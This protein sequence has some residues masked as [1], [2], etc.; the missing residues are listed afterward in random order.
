MEFTSKS[1][2]YA[3]FAANVYGATNNGAGGSPLVRSERN[4]LPLP[5][6]D[7]VIIAERVSA[8]GFMARAYREISTGRVIIAYAGTTEESSMDWYA[9]NVPAAA[10]LPSPQVIE[11]ARF[12]MDV[13]NSPYGQSGTISFTGH[14]LGGGLASLMAVYFNH[15]AIVFD[16][17]PFEKSADSY[18]AVM[19]VQVALV[20]QGYQ[21]PESFA[22]YIA[23]DQMGG[24]FY[25]S[26]SR[27]AR[28]HN[29]DQVFVTGEVLSLA[30]RVSTDVIAQIASRINIPLGILALSIDKIQSTV[31]ELDV[32]A[33]SGYGWELLP[34]YKGGNPVDLH[35][36]SLLAGLLI[37]EDFFDATKDRQELLARVFAGQYS[38]IKSS[39]PRRSTLL[40][41]LIQRHVAD[42]QALDVLAADIGKITGQVLSGY[43]ATFAHTQGDKEVTMTLAAALVDAVLAGMYAQGNGRPKDQFVKVFENFLNDGVGSL[44]FDADD[45]G[46]QSSNGLSALREYLNS[47]SNGS[48]RNSQILN[49]ARWTIQNTAVG[50]SSAGPNDSRSDVMI[51]V[52]GNNTF[53]GGGGDDIL[54]GGIG[55]DDFSGESGN[56]TLVGGFGADSYRFYTSDSSQDSTDTIIDSW[57][58]GTIFFDDVA[59]TAGD[60]ISEATW[61]DS[62]KKLKLTYIYESFGSALVISVIDTG[63]IIRVMGWS[64]GELGIVLSG[65]VPDVTGISMTSDADLFGSY[66]ANA[67]NDIVNGLAGNDG[68]E[69][70]AG[71][72]YLNGGI[73]S[74]LILGGAG[75]DRLFGGAGNDFIYDGSEQ[76]D[77]R[78]LSTQPNSNGKS[79]LDLFEEDVLA[80]GSSLITKGL[81]WYVA[82]S[83]TGHVVMAPNW[84]IH[85]PDINPGGSDVID[86]GDGDDIVYA[87][88]GDDV[89]IGGEGH[90]TLVGG[91]DHD[92]ISGGSGND[93]IDGDTGYLDPPQ[94]KLTFRVSTGANID[95]N[96]II[97]AG[98]GDDIVR[99]NGGSDVIYGG[100]GNDEL[101]GRGLGN[102]AANPDDLDSDYIDGGSGND[103]IFGDDGNDM[104]MGNS[105]NDTIRG[106]NGH[107]NVRA[108]DD[109]IDGGLGDD[110]LSGDGGDD[111]IYGGAGADTLRGDASDIAGAFHGHDLLSGG[112]G[113]DQ[114][115]GGGG[116][117]ILYGDDGDDQ[118]FGDEVA[119]ELLAAQFHGDDVIYGGKGDDLL[120]G[121][122]GD[123]T[124]SGGEDNDELQGG[125]GNDALAGG[126]GNDTLFGGDGDDVLRGDVGVDTL[127]G[128]AG[129]DALYGGEG[130][131]VLMGEHGDDGLSGGSGDDVLAGG[132]G[133]DS[134]YGEQGDDQLDGGEGNDALFGGDGNDSLYGGA[135]ND[136]I[137]G[138][139]GNDVINGADGDDEIAG[140]DGNDSL[141][142]MQG[143][144]V[145]NG[146]SGDDALKGGQGNDLLAGGSGTNAYYFDRGF[147]SD[148]VQLAAGSQDTLQFQDGI[149]VQELGFSC[150]GD[151]LLIQMIGQSDQIVITNFF[152]PGVQ[153]SIRT[154]DGNSY[155]RVAFEQG[156]MLTQPTYGSANGDSLNGTNLANR[157]YGLDGNDILQGGEGAD[158]LDG[159][160]GNDTLSDGLGSDVMLGGAGDDIFHF[161][162]GGSSA[163]SDVATGGAGNDTYYVPWYSGFDR[164]TGLGDASSGIDRIVLT[165]ISSLMVNNYQISG[166]DLHLIVGD[167]WSGATQNSLLLEGFLKAGAPT[168]VIEFSNGITMTAADFN[169]ASWSGTSGDDTYAGGFVPDSIDGADGNDTLSG[170][171]GG[172]KIWG[173][174]GNDV[175][176]GNEGNDIL[177][178]GTG[179]DAVYG[180][181]GDD[182]IHSTY[183]WGGT[184]Q[185]RGGVGDDTYYYL[186]P[187]GTLTSSVPGFTSN[188]IEE[189]PGEGNDTVYTNYYHFTLSGTEVENLVAETVN[190]GWSSWDNVPVYRQLVGNH[191]NNT[192]RVHHAGGFLNSHDYYLLDGG[193]G[194][195]TLY[196]SISFDTYV[197]DSLGDV[198]VEPVGSSSIDTVRSS[199]SYS[200]AY[201]SGVENIELTSSDT[202]ATGNSGNNRLD[203]SMATGANTLIGGSGDD[204][205]IIDYFD[206]VVEAENGGYDKIVIKG[207]NSVTKTFTIPTGLNVEIFE[208]HESVS[209]GYALQGDDQN[210]ILVGNN[211]GNT[212]R[213]G[214]GDDELRAKGN[215]SSSTD[216]LYGE[217]GN[218]LLISQSGSNILVGGV[219]NDTIQLGYGTDQIR[220]D[221]GDGVDSIFVIDPFYTAGID[222]L[223]FGPY[224]NS[225][226]VIWSRS[227]NDLVITFSDI[228]NDSITI[229]GYWKQVDGV[230]ELSGVVDQFSFWNESGYRVGSTPEALNN[231]APV[232]NYW[233]L[234]AAAPIGMPF[235]YTLSADSFSDEDIN[236]LVYSVDDLPAWLT[237]NPITK[238]FFGTPSSDDAQG[239]IQVTAT[240]VFGAKASISLTISIMNVIEGTSGDDSLVGTSEPDMLIGLAGNDTLNGG[241]GADHMIGGL[242][243]DSYT[244]DNS[245]DLI[246]E[247]ELEG[248]DLVTS[249]VSY[250]LGENVENLTLSGSA[251]SGHG[252]E[253][254]NSI[255]GNSLANYLSGGAGDDSLVGNNG[256]DELD[257]DSGNDILNGGSGSDYMRGGEGDDLYIVGSAGDTVEEWMLE[258]VDTVQSSVTYTLSDNVEHLTLTGSSAISGSGNDLQ[259]SL[260]GNS[261]VNTL[262]GYAGDDYLDGKAGNDT[263]IGGQGDDTYQVGSTGDV[264]TELAGEGS[265]TVVSIVTY[266]LSSNVEH[267]TLTGTAAINGTGNALSN[268]LLGNSNNNSLSGLAGDDLLEGMGGT[269]TLTGGLGNDTYHMARTYGAD[270]VV[271]N[272]V[273]AGNSDIARFLT[274]VTYDQ[275]WFRRPASSNNLEIS[276]IGTTDKLVIKDWYLGDRYRVEEIRVDDGAKVLHAA[277]VQALVAAMATLTMPAQGQTTLNSTQ[278]QALSSTFSSTWQ[279]QA[280]GMRM[281]LMGN[282]NSPS[283][284]DLIEVTGFRA[285][286]PEIFDFV[287]LRWARE[288]MDEVPIWLNE[289]RGLRPLEAQHNSLAVWPTDSLMVA[290]VDQ[291]SDRQFDKSLYSGSSNPIGADNFTDCQRL[292]Q[293]M[294]IGDGS[295]SIYAERIYSSPV[296]PVEML[297]L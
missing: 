36:I 17:A 31:R 76:A 65:S 227:E 202:I 84:A 222:T 105:G 71:D 197:V 289:I 58:D 242:G 41:L 110:N 42:E 285:T 25:P 73:G 281:S 187:S 103:V 251:Y 279:D 7:W 258:G 14:S 199:I 29:V 290:G 169:V 44:H 140:G 268:T 136:L 192:I 4:T 151:A 234:S 167:P 91:H 278:L 93:V 112:D 97:D 1:A 121:N 89:V 51:G 261:G 70:G 230:D 133:H 38:D 200:L 274:G 48:I 53:L 217:D 85:S 59:V 266:T 96:D 18:A 182:Q 47:V 176:H 119:G 211:Y 80:I 276:I 79:E 107:A 10:G 118:I 254:D 267:L 75:D 102:T 159:G 203:G 263:M 86:A 95:G 142:G 101:S 60:R 114:I 236:S 67:G 52:E 150:N 243:N 229:Q 16:Q 87:G 240:D 284:I 296:K 168:H 106:D 204:T 201:V 249:S 161:T 54:I 277:N 34:E 28:E 143:N 57:G 46:E 213:G 295:S 233:S 164:I 280:Q 116:S 264:V 23:L 189:L 238:T 212:L 271:E 123:D 214:G 273:T 2:L 156:Y 152:A 126:A 64:S 253:L 265:D 282:Q 205:Y 239:Y 178:D 33:Q 74:D 83:S 209:S 247:S 224:I 12:Y 21:L 193:A 181:A 130:N 131:D 241:S 117:D 145:L 100:S 50:I 113:N 146:G 6:S 24:A 270:T 5:S 287:D 137:G 262:R 172:D 185:L 183:S 15:E 72:D 255:T 56:D 139:A 108:G 208:M 191:L 132:A 160:N 94:D 49:H 138:D 294:A 195:D 88:E 196:G 259:N 66:G 218:D 13:L 81:S 62:T 186:A 245:G 125:H 37:S 272:D 180:D 235:T 220:Y 141:S 190:Y 154:A 99:G 225:N 206:E 286:T 216:Y 174:N 98:D 30:G 148:I 144:D 231:R 293:M 177:Y 3:L 45:L 19:A 232:N 26:P 194:N 257:G 170:G 11:A 207:F 171:P 128:G 269:D 90:D 92:S 20:A 122:G 256:N 260:I 9:G 27:L 40:E 250:H 215:T 39:D 68:I 22:E 237:F 61:Y 157:L 221:R 111:A 292:I 248:I 8:T 175:I 173:G 124:L 135:G 155:G 77:L 32:E 147:G 275:L 165:G 291:L 78:E 115:N 228:A 104:L 166:N 109:T 219:G 134:L 149:A 129:N 69:G 127:N 244:V 252:N 43:A 188:E 223:I 210:N 179:D 297:A 55:N 288:D 184:D 283:A 82:S 158:L 162:A 63:D 163:S 153:A 198:I 226:N 35:S 120:I 246:I